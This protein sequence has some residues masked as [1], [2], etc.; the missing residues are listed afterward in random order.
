MNIEIAQEALLSVYKPD[1]MYTAKNVTQFPA[2]TKTQ[3]YMI[4]L[5]TD[6]FDTSYKTINNPMYN[7]KIGK[8]NF[9]TTDVLYRT[10]IGGRVISE[11]IKSEIIKNFNVLIHKDNPFMKFAIPFKVPTLAAGLNNMIVDLGNWNKLYFANRKEGLS[12]AKKIEEYLEFISDKI[13]T[14]HPG[15]YKGFFY[16]P[17]DKWAEKNKN[18]IKGT[19]NDPVSIIMTALFMD[20]EC[21]KNFPNVD[22]IL[23]SEAT[24][25]IIVINRK[26]LTKE[27]YTKLK[28]QLN[29]FRELMWNE[30]VVDEKDTNTNDNQPTDVTKLRDEIEN[31][32][33]L[34]TSILDG[35]VGSKLDKPNQVTVKPISLNQGNEPT[36]K[37]KEE[38]VIIPERPKE[39]E[40]EDSD[41]AESI[42]KDGLQ[43]EDGEDSLDFEI[44]IQTSFKREKT[45]EQ[46]AKIEKLK[47]KQEDVITK[48]N[49][50]ESKKI[51]IIDFS[52]SIQAIN[53]NI[54]KSKFA[55]FEKS[56]NEKRLEYDIDQVIA[57]LNDGDT[58]V[59]ITKKEVKDSS[60]NLNIKKTYIYTLEDED[61]RK[62]TLSFDL[63]VFIEDRY[64]YIGGNKKLFQNQFALRPLVKSG[65]NTVQLVSF[66]NKI[67]IERI[68]KNL[69]SKTTALKRFLGFDKSQKT[70]TIKFG[71][72]YTGNNTYRRTLDFDAISKNIFYLANKDYRIYFKLDEL[73]SKAKDLNID[74]SK[75]DKT[76]YFI[77]GLDVKNKRPLSIAYDSQLTV[78]DFILENILIPEDKEKLYTVSAGKKFMYSEASIQDKRI[79]LILFLLYAEGLTSVLEKSKINHTI[80]R[81]KDE[82]PKYDNLNQG[83]IEFMDG[84]LI[85]DKYPIENSILF[86]GLQSLPLAEFAIAE[87]DVKDTYIDLMTLFYE[88]RNIYVILDMFVEYMID[89]KT[90]EILE[91]MNLPTDLVGVLIEANKLLSNNEFMPENNM[92]NLRIRNN[93]ILTQLIYKEVSNAYK[94]FRQTRHKK[95]PDKINIKK[96]IIL[97]KIALCNIVEDVSELNA[98]LSAEKA[99]AIT[100]KGPGGINLEEAF[101][102]EKRAYDP[103]MIGIVGITTSADGGVGVLRQLTLEPNIES[104]LGYPK[105]TP[106]DKIDELTQNQLFTPAE[107]L[108]PNGVMHNDSA[109]VGMSQKQ[110][111]VM[112]LLENS[113]PVIIGNKVESIL[114]H[115]IDNSLAFN[116]KKNGFV[117]EITEDWI[118]L[119]YEDG[120][121]DAIDISNRMLKNGA[122]GIFI[123]S[124]I[125]SN[126]KVGDKFKAKD[127]I[128]YD[129]R[130]FTPNLRDNGVSMNVGTL[131]KVAIYPSG[132]KFED[133]A[134]ITKKLA[135]LL[136]TDVVMEESFVLGK[137]SYID[138][139]V[140]VGD[141]V[142]CGDE[143][144]AF[145]ES[146]DDPEVN[147]F[148]ENLRS[149]LKEELIQSNIQKVNA[150]HSGEVVDIKIYS[151]VEM[152]ELSDSL[153]EL[154]GAKFK[155]LKKRNAVL[156]KYKNEGDMATYK[157]GQIISEDSNI[158]ASK[159]GVLKGQEVGEGVLVS[160][161][162]KHKDIAK[163]GDKVT[164]YTALKG[165]ISNVVEE[166]YEPFSEFRPEEPIDTSIAPGAILA[167][168]TPSIMLTMFGNKCMIEFTRQLRDYWQNN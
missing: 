162:I 83:L 14:Y 40:S 98:L 88:Y 9:Y 106:M 104:T 70:Y 26:S 121:H 103:T 17:V 7:F 134:P 64:M 145:D 146:Y 62:S 24:E 114:S 122:N 126:Y 12:K 65:P 67:F 92:N 37:V 31:T 142:K 148:F 56:Y 119:E 18:D 89:N 152:D 44:P 167:R 25:Q 36:S 80:I 154:V 3:A 149:E 125:I 35:R 79:P 123:E 94:K 155:K 51:D 27:N 143:L 84:Y 116:A 129:P 38:R 42:I 45:P 124:K 100:Y 43:L 73:Y 32:E 58:A 33:K 137:N 15:G 107:L 128:A 81:S 161:Y 76:K 115:H 158:S 49:L 135:N 78:T 52:D 110:A 160:I 20:Y 97:S 147:K 34:D 21:V 61:G 41:I 59:F 151:T 117:K 23:A 75:V 46:K 11:S 118:I 5:C 66:Y 140:K 105:I 19:L 130:A 29:K 139:I 131:V 93:E 54:K 4:F 111:K 74:L 113:S 120:T 163:K 150:K 153:K 127:V 166:G 53:E 68:G 102:I 157:C 2:A 101:K 77:F 96:D 60:D 69:D 85:W 87:M 168:K 39:L 16:V 22:L 133:S 13:N 159:F 109:R 47:A 6:S 108:E 99:R 82:V 112:M 86:N 57:K 156:E 55:S 28:T 63:P 132:D 165:I 50:E 72:A 90:K 30:Q 10:N 71:N 1:K 164:N 95:N 48:I 144:I 91:D 8:Y 141:H 136:A 138:R